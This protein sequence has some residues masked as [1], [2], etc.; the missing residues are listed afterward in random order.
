MP[1]TEPPAPETAVSTD[2]VED[3]L[4]FL[5]SDGLDGYN[6]AYLDEHTKREV[7]RSI[8]KAIALPGHQVP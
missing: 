5:D 8:L 6:Y 4:D 2:S 1:E 7:R 3:V